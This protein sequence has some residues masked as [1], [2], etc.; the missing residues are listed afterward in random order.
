MAMAYLAAWIGPVTEEA[1]PYGD[2]Y[3]PTGFLR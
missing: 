1:D 2:G 3:S